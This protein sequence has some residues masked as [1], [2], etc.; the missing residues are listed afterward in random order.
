MKVRK[1]ECKR[2]G[3]CCRYLMVGTNKAGYYGDQLITGFVDKEYLRARGLQAV[4]G[5]GYMKI[6][7]ELPCLCLNSEGS[8]PECMI[9]PARPISCQIYPAREEDLLPGCGYYF[10]EEDNAD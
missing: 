7:A 10:E 8:V 6:V 4:V 5:G 2:C 9:Y 3:K 1:G